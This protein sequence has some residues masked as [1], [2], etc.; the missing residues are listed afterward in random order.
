MPGSLL[1]LIAQASTARI[2]RLPNIK[3][4]DSKTLDQYIG[5]MS[6]I[7]TTLILSKQ[8]GEIN[9]PTVV[10]MALSKLPTP[11]R[12]MW[13]AEVTA[14]RQDMSLTSLREWLD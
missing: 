11:W 7:I 3:I 14:G 12:N 2:S 4:D 5:G 1:I 10:K 13:G 9:S 8:V 6:E